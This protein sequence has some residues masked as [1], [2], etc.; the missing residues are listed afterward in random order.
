MPRCWAHSCCIGYIYQ[1]LLYSSFRWFDSTTAYYVRQRI[2]QNYCPQLFALYV[3]LITGYSGMMDRNIWYAPLLSALMLHWIHISSV[4]LFKLP[5]IWLNNSI[6]RQAED[7]AKP[8]SRILY[9]V[10]KIDYWIFGHDGSGYL[11]LNPL[12]YTRVGYI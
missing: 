2:E 10:R 5:L 4:A 12:D 1:A 6:L 8:L 11:L 3:K 7:R 9:R